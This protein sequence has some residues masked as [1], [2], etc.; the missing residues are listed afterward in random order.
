MQNIT[1]VQK[2]YKSFE[3]DVISFINHASDGLILM[4]HS[5]RASFVGLYAVLLIF[6]VE[7]LGL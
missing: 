7:R 1:A 2:R 3:L 4:N 6:N 5:R